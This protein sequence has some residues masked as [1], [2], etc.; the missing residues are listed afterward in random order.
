MCLVSTAGFMYESKHVMFFTQL[1]YD[2]V[3][4][5]RKRKEE[6][7]S[8]PVLHTP[9][10]RLCSRKAESDFKAELLSG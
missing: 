10:S 6:K 2:P 9:S 7:Q 4:K 8:V 1:Q 3:A 5:E